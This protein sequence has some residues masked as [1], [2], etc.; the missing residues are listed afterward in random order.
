MTDSN[1][2][3]FDI[4]NV[5]VPNVIEG[6]RTLEKYRRIHAKILADVVS[7]IVQKSKKGEITEAET[8]DLLRDVETMISVNIL[9]EEVIKDSSKAKIVNG[10]LKVLQGAVNAATGLSIKIF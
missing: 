10:I 3:V 9:A 2:L 4:I 7:D 1:K 6:S 8:R 5:I